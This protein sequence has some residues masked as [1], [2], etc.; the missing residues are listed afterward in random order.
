MKSEKAE[1]SHVFD[2]NR[3]LF[4]ITTSNLYGN[5]PELTIVQ[6]VVETFD[7]PIVTTFLYH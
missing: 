1:I 2:I 5:F 6:N 7:F 4:T 3:F